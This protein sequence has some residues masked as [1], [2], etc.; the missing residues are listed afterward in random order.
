MALA[1]CMSNR[2]YM[3]IALAILMLFLT[4]IAQVRAEGFLASNTEVTEQRTEKVFLTRAQQNRI[5]NL[6]R[7]ASARM[8]AA[9]DRLTNISERLNTRIAKLRATGMQT[10][11]AEQSLA[12]AN[13]SLLLAHNAIT[14][15]QTLA[16]NAIMSGTPRQ[17]FG[18][19]RTQ[20]ASGIEAIHD[21][22]NFLQQAVAFLKNAI[23]TKSVGN[24]VSPAVQNNTAITSSSK[25]TTSSEAR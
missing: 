25:S 3:Y 12:Q 17:S 20:F 8:Q 5:I 24:G 19:A 18:L 4:P 6:T 7:N 16:E 14:K 1:S 9:E 22:R 13:A 23:Q 10:A 15:A 2:Q 21:A 11:D